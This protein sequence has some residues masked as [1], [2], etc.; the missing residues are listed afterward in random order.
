VVGL[1]ESDIPGQIQDAE[2]NWV[3][4]EGKKASRKSWKKIKDNKGTYTQTAPL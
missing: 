3:K 2:S 1:W 4:A